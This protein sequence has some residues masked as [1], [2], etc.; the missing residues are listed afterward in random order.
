MYSTSESTRPSGLKALL[1]HEWIFG[2]LLAF[3]S[4]RALDRLGPMD[5]ATWVPLV[6][7]VAD[8]GLIAW[9][10]KRESPRSGLIR[11]LFH[12][13][14]MC[15][16][17]FRLG[18]DIPRLDATRADAWLLAV[19]RGILGETPSVILSA[20]THP[21]ATELLS[22]CYLL[23]YVAM[24][25]YHWVW[26]TESMSLAQSFC[27]GLYSI[28]AVGF[29]GYSLLPA[30]G[31]WVHLASSLKPLNG[32]PITWLT[33]QVV[34]AGCNGVDV[35]PSLHCAVTVYFIGFD[36]LNGRLR[37][38][39]LTLAPGLGLCVA[40]LYLGYHYAVDVFAGILLACVALLLIRPTPTDSSGVQRANQLGMETRHGRDAG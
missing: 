13:V 33:D 10:R 21:V 40:T 25:G 20:H 14:A 12:P 29:L 36:L 4:L 7:L 3:L 23:F 34:R 17:Y 11:L 15:L 26:L 18:V 8:A 37:R 30:A 22:L 27:A 16:L 39:L 31:P 6:L 2:G 1:I 35:L 19:D 24:I 5:P 38:L 28:Y 9:D 32:G